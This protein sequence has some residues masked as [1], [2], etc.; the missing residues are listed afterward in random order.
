MLIYVGFI[1]LVG[2]VT[3]LL[4]ILTL[5]LSVLSA[6]KGT[7]TYTDTDQGQGKADRWD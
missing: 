3:L 6:Y 2:F 7:L 4:C 5:I 1:V